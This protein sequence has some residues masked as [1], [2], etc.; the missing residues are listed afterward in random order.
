MDNVETF[1]QRLH[2]RIAR[3]GRAGTAAIGTPKS[4]GSKLISVSGD[5]PRPG[6]YEYPF[7][8]TVAQIL[9]DCGAVNTHA[10][11]VSPALPASASRKA[12]STAAWASK[13]CPRPGPFMVFD[14]SRDLFEVARN[15]AHFFAHESCGFCTPCRV[16]TA[17]LKQTMDKIAA[18]GSAYDMGEMSSN[19]IM[20]DA[21]QLPLR[22]GAHRLQSGAAHAQEFP[23]GLRKPPEVAGLR[24][25]LRSRRRAGT[26]APDDRTRRRRGAPEQRREHERYLHQLDGASRSIPDDGPD[27]H[28]GRA[29]LPGS[30]IPHLCY[31]PEFKP[32]GSCKLCTVK[33]GGRRWRSCTMP[34]E[35]G[36]E[37]ESNI[38]ELND[39]RRTLVQMLFV[40][41]N[42][43]C[44]SCEKPAATA[45]CRLPPT[46]WG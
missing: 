34:A 19:S 41:G 8:V 30:Y 4:A 35:A 14:D 42:H 11:Q 17:L 7:G 23:P 5:C 9:P 27:H 6:I 20:P 2:W 22:A 12:S 13:T 36:L 25:G 40:E 24:T 28:A 3:T 18:D 37:V 33:T 43:F 21:D 31:H 39:L 26:R 15:F 32:H 38:E 45:S 29:G 46:N 44:P 10:V 16:G 1:C